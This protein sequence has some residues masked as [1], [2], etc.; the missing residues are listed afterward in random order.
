MA[1]S[2]TIS[3]TANL[4]GQ[5]GLRILVGTWTGNAGDAAGSITI[6]GP[7]PWMA[8]FQKFDPLDN[9]YEIVPRVEASYVN[10]LTTYTI[11][12]QDNVTQGRFTIIES[13]V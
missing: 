10:G 3:G 2:F 9:T 8:I 13:G 1:F 7:I 11:E 4:G 12:N 5:N 6:A